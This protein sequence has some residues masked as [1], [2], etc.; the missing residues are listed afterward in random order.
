MI[1][2]LSSAPRAPLLGISSYPSRPQELAETACEASDSGVTCAAA[3]ALHAP[4]TRLN[5][6][7]LILLVFL[8]FPSTIHRARF[9]KFLIFHIIVHIVRSLQSSFN[10]SSLSTLGCTVYVH[11]V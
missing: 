9:D 8:L 4:Q 7:C 11:A 5:L 6:D 1:I 10:L 3:C 2:N